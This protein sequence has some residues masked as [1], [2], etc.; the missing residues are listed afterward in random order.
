MELSGA[1]WFDAGNTFQHKVIF[2]QT[3]TIIYHPGGLGKGIYLSTSTALTQSSMKTLW[4]VG[5]HRK[6]M[7][8]EIF[9]LLRTAPT[10]DPV[11]AW[12]PP[13]LMS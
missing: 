6:N 4:W 8:S 10:S 1:N 2:P 13:I 5:R 3:Y 7:R 12:K 9:I 11:S